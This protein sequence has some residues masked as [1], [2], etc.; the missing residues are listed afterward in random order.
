[1]AGKVA[2]SWSSH[3]FDFSDACHMVSFSYFSIEAKLSYLSDGQHIMCSLLLQRSVASD[4]SACTAV[5]S[6]AFQEYRYLLKPL[7]ATLVRR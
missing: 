1:M 2:M 3:G 4:C 7:E 5:K 6:N